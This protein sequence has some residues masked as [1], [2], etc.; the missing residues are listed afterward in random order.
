MHLGGMCKI[1]HTL[2]RCQNSILSFEIQPIQNWFRLKNPKSVSS[3]GSIIPPILG[4]VVEVCP[5]WTDPPQESKI[6]FS[7]AVLLARKFQNAENVRAES[8]NLLRG[9]FLP[10]RRE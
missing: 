6:G 2:P 5:N 10:G 7:A 4:L 3:P 1:A 9:R 8:V